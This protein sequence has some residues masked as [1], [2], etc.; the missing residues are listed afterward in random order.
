MSDVLERLGFGESNVPQIPPPLYL[1]Q[2]GS[3]AGV[4]VS[5]MFYGESAYVSLPSASPHSHHP[6]GCYRSVLPMHGRIALP[7]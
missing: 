5:A 7:C 6:R 1:G 3:F 4:L 2:K